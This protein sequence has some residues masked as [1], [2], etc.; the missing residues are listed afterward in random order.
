[1]P[2]TYLPA[3]VPI[4]KVRRSN[5]LERVFGINVDFSGRSAR[6]VVRPASE[7]AAPVLTLTSPSQITITSTNITVTCSAILTGT[8]AKGTYFYAL[9]VFTTPDDVQTVMEGIFEVV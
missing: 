4:S 5:Y 6:M 2:Q 7:T 3:N 9:D 8:V 1:M